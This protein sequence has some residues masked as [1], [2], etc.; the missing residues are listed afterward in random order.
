M[1]DLVYTAVVEM[2]RMSK[3]RLSWHVPA[4]NPGLWNLESCTPLP[5]K[6][7]LYNVYMIPVITYGTNVWSLTVASQRC[8]DA[9]DQ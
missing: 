2:I 7:R 4:R 5:I 6:I 9:F 8:L 3:Q 1:L